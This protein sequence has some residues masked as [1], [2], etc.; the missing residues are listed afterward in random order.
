MRAAEKL[1][2]ERGMENVSI[3]DIVAAAGQKNES[4]LQY[5]FRSLSGLLR[6]VR[7][8][9]S[10]QVQARRGTMLDA[11]QARTDTPT[12]RELCAVMVSPPFDLARS[13]TGFRRYIKA[14]GHEL[15][16]SESSALT[17]VSRHG[18]G[19]ASGA[20]LAALLRQALPHL[21]QKSYRQRMETA[22]RL[23]SASMYQQARQRNAFRGAQAAFFYN[24]LLDA[25]EGL[26]NAPVS[27]DT[28]RCMDAD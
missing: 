11:L 2:A 17:N 12:L 20:R 28:R 16:M 6:A 14:F 25:L 26:L 3:R 1:I 18:G 13:N 8:E 23:C 24:G 27:D 19:G 22:V 9:R 5:H 7:E 10:A 4:A 15:M 21:D